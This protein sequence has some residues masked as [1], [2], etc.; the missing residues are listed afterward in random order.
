M[1]ELKKFHLLLDL[2]TD[3]LIEQYDKEN[4]KN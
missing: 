1:K 3:K 2:I 4:G